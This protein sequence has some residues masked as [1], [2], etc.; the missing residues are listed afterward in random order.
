VIRVELVKQLRR[1]RTWV[2]LAIVAI[3]PAII[4]VAFALGGPPHG[5]HGG[6][7]AGLFAIATHSGINMPLAALTGMQ[8]F[9]LV[10]VTALFAGESLA[11]EAN[12]GSLR[13]L[14]V[15]P[16]GRGRLITAKLLVAA[17]LVGCATVLIPLVG[18]A[19]GV[20]AFGWHPVAEIPFGTIP[21]STAVLRLAESTGYVIWMLSGTLAFAL[22]LSTLTTSAFG[23]VFGGV[24]FAVVSEI[25]DAISAFG[26]F[27]YGLPTHYW[28]A[29]NGLFKA[30]TSTGDMITGV[31]TQI[32]YVVV[33]LG[34]AYWWFRRKDVLS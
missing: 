30:P 31:L 18:L 20:G 26:S 27:R 17:L 5:R 3:L 13:Y 7:R 16:V 15:R 12:W 33:F 32:P 1:P 10:I 4:T 29:W 6:T 9:L 23:A 2:T 34:L 24:A 11:G 22:F 28:Q 19:A 21:P 8:G 25:L 14:L